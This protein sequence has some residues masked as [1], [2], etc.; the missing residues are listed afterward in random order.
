MGQIGSK[1]GA[2]SGE[3]ATETSALGKLR[4]G[5]PEIDHDWNKEWDTIALQFKNKLRE[6]TQF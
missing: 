5:L 4:E 1:G 6:T 2:P 3:E